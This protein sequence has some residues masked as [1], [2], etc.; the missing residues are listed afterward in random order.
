MKTQLNSSDILSIT[1]S[2]LLDYHSHQNLKLKFWCWDIK[3]IKIRPFRQNKIQ[4][5]LQRKKDF[6]GMLYQKYNTTS[7]R[8][9]KKNAPTMTGKGNDRALFPTVSC[10]RQKQQK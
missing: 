9:H 2:F 8:L 7:N 6:A 10:I 1:D 3:A 5:E 4:M